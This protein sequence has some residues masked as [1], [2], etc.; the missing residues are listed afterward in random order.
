MRG[1]AIDDAMA[2]AR[3]FAAHRPADQRLGVDLLQPERAV[4]LEPTTDAAGSPRARRAA[5]LERGTRVYDAPRAG[6]R[7]ARARRHRRRL[8]DRPLRRRRRRQLAVAGRRDEPREARRRP[9]VRRRRCARAASTR[10]PAAMAAASGGRL[11]RGRRADDWPR[12]STRSARAWRRSS[13]QLP[14][15]AP[16]RADAWGSR[17]PCPAVATA[18]GLRAPPF[19]PPGGPPP[20]R[21]AGAAAAP[22]ARRSTGAL[23]VVLVL[24]LCCSCS[25]PRRRRWRSAS[26]VHRGTL[27][28]G[29]TEG[30]LRALARR[31]PPGA[32][33]PVAGI[34]EDST[35]RSCAWRRGGSPCVTLAGTA[36]CGGC[37]WRCRAGGD[38]RDAAPR[39]PVGVRLSWPPG[40]ATARAFEEQL[41]DNLQV[42][43]SA[44]RAGHSFIGALA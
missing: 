35:S 13:C 2:A 11:R 33:R 3:A 17:S 7:D 30:E 4:A 6:A 5:A 10:L 14:S 1:D 31:R 38:R 41:P 9:R 19:P 24:A 15:S 12:S 43:A 34:R 40:R 18:R 8:G 39:I 44:L 32:R 28:R 42:M 25:R 26:R 20:P 23:L 16:A 36:A 29:L 21:L 37:S 27:P 22:P